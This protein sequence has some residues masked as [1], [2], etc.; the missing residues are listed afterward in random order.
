[1]PWDLKDLTRIALTLSPPD[2]THTDFAWKR[3]GQKQLQKSQPSVPT[4]RSHQYTNGLLGQGSHQE[5]FCTLL[6]SLR[7]KQLQKS[8]SSESTLR[9][10]QNVNGLLGQGP[11]QEYLCTLL[12]SE[13]RH[14][15]PEY[16]HRALRLHANLYK[17]LLS[18]EGTRRECQ[19]NVSELTSST[20]HGRPRGKQGTRPDNVAAPKQLAAPTYTQKLV[21]RAPHYWE[22]CRK[23]SNSSSR[24]NRGTCQNIICRHM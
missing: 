9:P 11:H 22:D 21:A 17:G 14:F 15:H 10:P 18:Q 23:T 4:L 7:Q 12:N 8:Q 24:S 6:S 16:A 1:M 2:P 13:A 20:L 3:L 5:Y 19:Q